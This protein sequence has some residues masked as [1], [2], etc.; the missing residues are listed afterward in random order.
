MKRLPAL[1]LVLV[2]LSSAAPGQR[3][4]IGAEVLIE[5]HLDLIKGKGIG[6]VC[7]QASVFPDG[8]HLV[9]S[10]LHLGIAVKALF[11]PEHGIRGDAAAG[12]NV[13]NGADS[14]T[15]IPVY[16]LYGK[17]LIPTPEMLRGVDVLV[18]DLQ[19]VGARFYTYASTMAKVMEAGRD[20]SKKVIILD[21]PNPI[22]GI[23]VE[24]PVLDMT[25]ISFLGLFPLPV[26]H[27]LTLG[28]LARTIVGEGWLNYNS[29]VDLTVIPMEGWKRSMWYDETGLPWM[30]PSPNMKTLSTAAVYPGTCLFEATNISEGRGTPKPFEYIGAPNLNS[31]K[32]AARLN[33]LHLPGVVF[34]PA[35]FTPRRD[36]VAAP[37]PKYKDQLCNGLYVRVTDRKKF[38]PVLTGVM[39][40]SVLHTLYPR[41]FQLMQGRL[42]RLVGDTLIGE[43]LMKGAI[44]RNVL[45]VF[46]TQLDQ[47]RQLRAKYL[48]YP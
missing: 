23:D 28:E 8:T 5:K 26:R 43:K 41:K 32:A 27:G 10:L 47:F 44:G 20:E 7:N 17:T 45:D 37:D 29:K 9:D 35:T 14:L 11:S 12:A 38:R 42:D 33:A 46:N 1:L 31:G 22:N 34:R 3:V 15:G 40:L 16:S 18:V 48:L 4:R 6:I 39:M 2:L 21:R 19:D 36:P 25:L 24:G 13:A 30:A